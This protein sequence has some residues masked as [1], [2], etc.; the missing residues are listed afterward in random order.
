VRLANSNEA[1]RI[2]EECEHLGKADDCQMR[3][4]DQC[5]AVRGRLSAVGRLDE[6][7]QWRRQLGLRTCGGGKRRIA[8]ATPDESR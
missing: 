2:S 4:D 7:C 5:H 1:R 8:L 6:N 3:V